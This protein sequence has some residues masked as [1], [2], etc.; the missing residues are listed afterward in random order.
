MFWKKKKEFRER[1]RVLD[2]STYALLKNPSLLE[3]LSKVEETKGL[4]SD[5]LIAVTDDDDLIIVYES[6]NNNYLTICLP[7]MS[8][9]EAENCINSISRLYP[10]FEKLRKEKS[11]DELMTTTEQIGRHFKLTKNEMFKFRKNIEHNDFITYKIAK[12]RLRIIED[13]MG[14]VR[15]ED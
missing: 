15:K 4:V 12:G 1:D 8:R 7:S 10:I 13:K 6:I 9:D 14:W 2:L 5:N 11:E 3:T